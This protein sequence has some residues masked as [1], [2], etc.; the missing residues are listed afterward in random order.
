MY[1]CDEESQEK[2]GDEEN[3]E[4]LLLEEFDKQTF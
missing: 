3:Q 1:W 2:L 4:K